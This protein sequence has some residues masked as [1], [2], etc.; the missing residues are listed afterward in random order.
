M[1]LLLSPIPQILIRVAFGVHTHLG[2]IASRDD[3]N[4]ALFE[5]LIKFVL[6]CGQIRGL[7]GRLHHDPIGR[8]FLQLESANGIL[9]LKFAG[10]TDFPGCR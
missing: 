4:L 1:Q 2:R 8:A 7:D 10:A 3:G 5:Q 6:A 9:Q